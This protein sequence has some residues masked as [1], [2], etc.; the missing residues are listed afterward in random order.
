[1]RLSENLRGLDVEIHAFNNSVTAVGKLEVLAP[2]IV[3]SDVCMPDMD[4]I[5]V[6]VN[7]AK[8]LPEAERVLLTG[9]SDIETDDGG[10]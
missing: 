2:S 1:M 9:Y 8:I 5:D 10:N 7:V 4:G 6:M 3:I